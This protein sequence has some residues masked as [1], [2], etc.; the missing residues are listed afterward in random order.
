[1]DGKEEMS[2]DPRAAVTQ[3][4]YNGCDFSGPCFLW[5]TIYKMGFISR[6]CRGGR[7]VVETW[8]EVS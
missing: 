7:N 6:G 4:T 1:M 2:L 5:P 8:F 3:M